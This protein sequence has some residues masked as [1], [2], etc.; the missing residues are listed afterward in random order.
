MKATAI[1]EIHARNIGFFYL[2]DLN[3]SRLPNPF[4]QLLNAYIFEEDRLCLL[5]QCWFVFIKRQY[6]MISMLLACPMGYRQFYYWTKMVSHVCEPWMCKMLIKSLR[7]DLLQYFRWKSHSWIRFHWFYIKRAQHQANQTFTMKNSIHWLLSRSKT[8]CY[9]TCS[10]VAT[11][12][13][14]AHPFDLTW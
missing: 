12:V 7:H 10:T 11:Q 5:G 13:L 1:L 8:Y 9:M 2:L 6:V 14:L 4:H 3:S